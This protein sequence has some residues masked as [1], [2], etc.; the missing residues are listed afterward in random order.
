MWALA[1]EV[2]K[3]SIYR[4][5]AI[6]YP[7]FELLDLFGP[8]EMFTTLPPEQLEVVIVGEQK[9]PI[10]SASMTRQSG[11]VILADYGFD[12]APQLDMLLV[13]GGVGTIPALADE[14]LLG[15]LKTRAASA[16][17]VAT[18]CTGSALLARAGLLDGK[19]ATSNKQF[20]SLATSQSDKVQWVERARWVED[21]KF[22]TSS[23]VSA[24]TDMALAIIERLYG[25][26]AAVTIAEGAEYTW[27]R[28][29]DEDPFA[30]QLNRLASGADSNQ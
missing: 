12:D 17:I 21:G 20:F 30:D 22:V 6:V 11:P 26:Q 13:P 14:S 4:L 18:V 15:F 27:H 10:A 23:G 16:E 24:G 1:N 8:L 2:N 28:D 9:G 29:A 5:G 3:L 19:R 7:G 25:E